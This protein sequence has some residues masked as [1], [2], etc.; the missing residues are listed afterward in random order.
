MARKKNDEGETLNGALEGAEAVAVLDAPTVEA[1]EAKPRKRGKAV[2]ELKENK[3]KLSPARRNAIDKT[4]G[5]LTK[6]FGEGTIMRLGD[7]NLMQVDSI[8]TG[9]L[10][11]D[12]ALGIGGVPRGRVIEI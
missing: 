11:L 8:P 12:I 10:S 2:E 6:K 4:L 9:A 5:D 1:S 3:L 7:A